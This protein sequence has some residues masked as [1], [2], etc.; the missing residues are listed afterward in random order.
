MLINLNEDGV[1]RRRSMIVSGGQSAGSRSKDV[2]MLNTRNFLPC[3]LPL[4]DIAVTE[5]QIIVVAVFESR[6]ADL[7][8]IRC[9]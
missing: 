8:V 7:V 4:H 2:S 9:R 1:V 5:I 3:L 6:M